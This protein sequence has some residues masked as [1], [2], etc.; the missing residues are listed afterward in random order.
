[1]QVHYGLEDIRI[2]NPVVTIGS[3]DGV[4]LGHVQVIEGLK[5][6]ARR[7]RG[8]SVIISFDPHPREVL[9]PLEKRPG[10]LTT[11]EEKIQILD[12]LG[13]DYLIILRFTE[14]LAGLSYTDFV[15]LLVDKLNI[16]GLIVGYDHRFGKDREGSF[17]NLQVLADRYHFYLEQENVYETDQVSI[18]STKIRT[19][20]ELG[21]IKLVKTYLGYDYPLSG[22]VVH[23]D[24]IG[25][26]IGFPT[27]NL[28]INDERKLLPV[29]GVYAVDVLIGSGKYYGMLNIG[30]RPTVSTSGIVRLEVNIFDFDQNI[31]GENIRLNLLFRIRGE[32]KF[33]N[34]AE[35]TMQLKKDRESVLALLKQ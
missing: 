31:Y 35:L 16:K 13:V 26:K 19:A 3:F 33:E 17:A 12:S 24:K 20:L 34:I 11:L 6:S 22:K 30:T 21:D 28:K 9:Y 32:R 8:K 27:A 5:Q 15:K 18:S 23:G 2:E 10:I 29:S 7:L 4:H 14:T 1:M 25:Q